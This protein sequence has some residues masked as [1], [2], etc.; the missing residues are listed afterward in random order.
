MFWIKVADCVHAKA[1]AEAVTPLIGG[2][3]VIS[4]RYS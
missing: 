1:D 4:I 2:Y 3:F